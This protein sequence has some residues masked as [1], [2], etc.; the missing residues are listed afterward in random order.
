[1]KYLRGLRVS[2]KEKR[3]HNLRPLFHFDRM[4]LRGFKAPEFTEA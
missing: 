4:M 2:T 1:M 3:R